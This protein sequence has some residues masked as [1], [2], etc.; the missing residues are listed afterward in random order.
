MKAALREVMI[1]GD[2]AGELT[3]ATVRTGT[4]E[5]LVCGDVIEVDCQLAEGRIQDLAWRA[6]GCPAILAVAA[7]AS[8]ALPGARPQDASGLLSQRLTLLGGLDPGEN[9]AQRLFLLALSRAA[10]EGA[11]AP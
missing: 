4:A 3:G 9:H 10:V 7:A 5:H 6:E 11:P 2:G 1:R 8:K